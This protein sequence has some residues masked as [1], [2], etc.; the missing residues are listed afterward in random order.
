V[1][2]Q[3]GEPWKEYVFPGNKS[4]EDEENLSGILRAIIR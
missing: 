2:V 4:G 3:P 1:L